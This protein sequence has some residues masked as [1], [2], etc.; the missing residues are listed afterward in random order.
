MNG[1]AALA[2]FHMR[3]EDPTQDTGRQDR[4]RLVIEAIIHNLIQTDMLLSYQ[5]I[6]H[7]LS[8]NVETSLQMS[9]YLALQQNGY[10]SAVSNIKQDHLGGVGGLRDEIYY[11]F[12][13]GAELNRVQ[14]GLEN[15]VGITI[16]DTKKDE[17]NPLVFFVRNEIE[18]LMPTVC[19]NG[20]LL[21]NFV[22]I[23]IFP[24]SFRLID[25]Y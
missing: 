2:F 13:D 11:N 18:S 22:K 20:N 1:E 25:L 6:L 7:S 5:D 24:F 14:R 3:E 17:T 23:V 10:V 12:V 21:Y 4:Q 19:D 9:D 16:R 15:R 8:A